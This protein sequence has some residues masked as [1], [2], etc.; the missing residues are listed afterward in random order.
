VSCSDFADGVE[1]RVAGCGM[2]DVEGIGEGRL[3]HLTARYDPAGK[4]SQERGFAMARRKQPA[5]SVPGWISLCAWLACRHCTASLFAAQHNV[6][7]PG[8]AGFSG[9]R[10]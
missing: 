1:T 7:Q 9:G 5:Q 8:P 6:E 10:E 4:V 3:N 2:R